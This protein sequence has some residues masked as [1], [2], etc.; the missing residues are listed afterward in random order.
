MAHIIRYNVSYMSGSGA[1]IRYKILKR[2]S[3]YYITIIVFAKS[4]W[5]LKIKSD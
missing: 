3:V 1:I 5:S 4:C 2:N